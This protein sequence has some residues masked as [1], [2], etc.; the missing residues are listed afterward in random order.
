MT[1]GGVAVERE[2]EGHRPLVLVVDDDPVVQKAVRL[3]LEHREYAVFVTSD[4]DSALRLIE[5]L[6]PDVLVLD[7]KLPG[8]SGP[9]VA[10]ALGAV[11]RRPRLLICSGLAEAEDIARDLGADAVVKKPFACSDLRAEIERLLK[12]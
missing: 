6:S 12:K 9:M 11:P 7:L 5:T 8:V 10:A 2:Q 1:F 4:G 3:E